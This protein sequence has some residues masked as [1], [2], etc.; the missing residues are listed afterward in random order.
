M[1]GKAWEK[2]GQ[3]WRV[4]KCFG[5]W[6]WEDRIGEFGTADVGIL[7]QGGKETSGLT[8][9]G[10]KAGLWGGWKF[11]VLK[12]NLAERF[13]LYL[14]VT[15]QHN[16][17]SWVFVLWSTATWP[18][19]SLQLAWRKQWALGRAPGPGRATHGVC[20]VFDSTSQQLPLGYHCISICHISSNNWLEKNKTF[21]KFTTVCKIC[22]FFL[23]RF[24][25]KYHKRWKRTLSLFH[26]EHRFL[27]MFNKVFLWCLSNLKSFC[28]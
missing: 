2:Y 3:L 24:A 21:E 11:S 14:P 17:C 7:E 16:L 4:R 8:E 9:L 18:Y 10:K 25:T 23:R 5:I 13:C 22:Y 6:E 26:C 28:K 27:K 1:D 20:C 12:A 15:A 19:C